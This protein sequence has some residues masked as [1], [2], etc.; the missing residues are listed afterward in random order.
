[1]RRFTEILSGSAAMLFQVA[2]TGWMFALSEIN[3]DFVTMELN[4]ILLSAVMLLGYYINMAVM[5]SLYM[6]E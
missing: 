6:T 2:L 5:R 3:F 4:Y 1:M